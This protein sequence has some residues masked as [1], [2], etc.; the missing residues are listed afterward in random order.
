[1]LAKQDV[2]YKDEPCRN[3]AEEISPI[4]YIVR[5]ILLIAVVVYYWLKGYRSIFRSEKYFKFKSFSII[6]NSLLN[7][8]NFSTHYFTQSAQWCTGFTIVSLCSM[9]STCSTRRAKIRLWQEVHPSSNF[10]C[11]NYQSTGSDAGPQCCWLSC[12]ATSS[13]HFGKGE[14]NLT[15]H[16]SHSCEE[17]HVSLVRAGMVCGRKTKM[18]MM[19]MTLFSARK[20]MPAVTGLPLSQKNYTPSPT[21]NVFSEVLYLCFPP[22]KIFGII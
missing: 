4:L 20:R 10:F 21:Q 18:I 16:P 14:E 6:K 2:K 8:P 19:M 22:T 3:Y 9:N 5:E 1:L 11:I 12:W 15:K 13:S 7:D 17:I